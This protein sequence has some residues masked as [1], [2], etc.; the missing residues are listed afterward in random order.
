M[1]R[2]VILGDCAS[3]QIPE[4]AFEAPQNPTRRGVLTTVEG[5]L[6]KTFGGLAQDQAR[7]HVRRLCFG[8]MGVDRVGGLDDW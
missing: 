3:Y 7:R 4:L 5:L 1:N 8:C 6:E 2:Q